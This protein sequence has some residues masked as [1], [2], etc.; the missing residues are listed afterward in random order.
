MAGDEEETFPLGGNRFPVGGD[1][2]PVGGNHFPVGGDRFPPG[3]SPPGSAS[4]SAASTAAVVPRDQHDVPS[5]SSRWV[6]KRWRAVL[7]SLRI[8]RD[9]VPSVI[10]SVSLFS[11]VASFIAAVLG[12]AWHPAITFPFQSEMMEKVHWALTFAPASSAQLHVYSADWVAQDVGWAESAP[13]AWWCVL[14]IPFS[15]HYDAYFYYDADGHRRPRALCEGG[16]GA[17]G[18]F[19]NVTEWSSNISR[20]FPAG[21]DGWRCVD[22]WRNDGNWPSKAFGGGEAP[23]YVFCVGV[24]GSKLHWPPWL[25]WSL[26]AGMFSPVLADLCIILLWMDLSNILDS[27]TAG[28]S[29]SRRVAYFSLALIFFYCVLHVTVLPWGPKGYLMGAVIALIFGIFSG[30]FLLLAISKPGTCQQ[31]VA[32]PVARALSWLYSCNKAD[33]ARA[34]YEIDSDTSLAFFLAK[35]YGKR[36]NWFKRAFLVIGFGLIV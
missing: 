9:L 2:F 4:Q 5:S 34:G 31:V 35:G 32:S 10:L 7:Y 26:W 12:G 14:P 23:D 16:T 36:V 17:G 15:L 29:F 24:V 1:R 21:D 20:S 18:Y 11:I 33:D 25:P 27:F 22:Q 28:P 30:G 6:W 13:D 3:S 8:A 19:E